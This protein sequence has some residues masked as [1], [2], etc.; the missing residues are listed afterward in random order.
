MDSRDAW[1]TEL[2]NRYRERTPR[3][4][5]LHGRAEEVM[6]RGGS[7]SLRLWKPYSFFIARGSGAEIVDVDGNVYIDYWQG[8]YANILGY[9]PTP[10][11][12]ALSRRESGGDLHSGFE[13]EY[14]VKLARLVLSGLPGRDLRIRFTT[15]GTLAATY[16]VM[17][18]LAYTGRDRILKVGGGWHGSS[19]ILLK[20]VKYHK[21]TGFEG[22]DSAGIPEEFQGRIDIIPFNDTERLESVI[23]DKGDRIAAFILEPFLGAGGFLAA[24]REFLGTARRLTAERGILLILDEII[25]G[26]RFGPSGVQALYGIQPDLTTFGKIIGGGH[27]VAAVVGRAEVMDECHSAA[28]EP[29]RVL[30]EGGT[31]SA[32][33]LY[34]RTGA[35]MLEFLTEH[36]DS[37]YPRLAD[38]GRRLRAGIRAA[39]E[40]EGVEAVVT[41]DPGGA[42]PGSSLFMLHFPKSKIR[43][44]NA[45]DLGDPEKNDLPLREDFL[46]LVL[47]LDGVHT[48]HG[49][50]AISTAHDDALIDR[51]I[52]AYRAAARAFKKKLSG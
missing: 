26:F 42:L 19:P 24:S 28:P 34:M 43:P 8:H 4:R 17:L 29:R 2:E 50:G 12:R 15:S 5:A 38:L 13:D 21:G 11:R 47:C 1:M 9:D 7:H 31:F 46:K 6:V 52:D 36:A 22:A 25:S 23:R 16:A 33:P 14:Q 10:I 20:G 32:H 45:E 39:F 37:V 3:S 48:I 18:S 41:G 40:A 27:A 49:G 30:F 44:G 51:T 35:A